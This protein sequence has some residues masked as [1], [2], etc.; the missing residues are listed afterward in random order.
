MVQ[1]H[2]LANHT[3]PP[4]AQQNVNVSPCF[5]FLSP[6]FV[7]WSTCHKACH[8]AANK[9]LCC[10]MKQSNSLC[11]HMLHCS[12]I[13][14]DSFQHI[15]GG[16]ETNFQHQINMLQSHCKCKHGLWA[17][18]GEAGQL[19]LHQFVFSWHCSWA[20]FLN[21]KHFFTG[22]QKEKECCFACCLFSAQRNQTC[23]SQQ[24]QVCNASITVRSLC[25]PILQMQPF[26]EMFFKMPFLFFLANKACWG[27]NALQNKAQ[28]CKMQNCEWNKKSWRGSQRKRR[29]WQ[30]KL[31]H[32]GLNDTL[33]SEVKLTWRSVGN[34]KMQIL[35]PS[36]LKQQTFRT[37]ESP[38]RLLKLLC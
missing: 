26:L 17:Q 4:C 28:T 12:L 3:L 21:Q 31:A 25:L 1:V 7:N 24:K 38:L 14:A 10:E 30:W 29:E 6:K 20:Q 27:H 19:L 2:M 8:N 5:L 16:E 15:W 9:N 36:K 34:G 33:L 13:K 22:L 37:A 11:H 18:S 35:P 23:F 32:M